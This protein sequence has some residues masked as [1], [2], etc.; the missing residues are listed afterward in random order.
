M[1]ANSFLG[2]FTPVEVMPLDRVSKTIFEKTFAVPTEVGLVCVELRVGLVEGLQ[3]R[4]AAIG[5]MQGKPLLLPPLSLP[6]P[7]LLVRRPHVSVK[8]RLHR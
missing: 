4:M 1:L 5:A 8:L 3:K 7:P 2:A 6:L